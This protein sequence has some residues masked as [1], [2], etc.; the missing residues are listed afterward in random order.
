MRISD[1]DIL[2]VPGLGN[3][4]QNHWQLDG[5]APIRDRL[6][7]LTMPTLV[8]HGTAYPLFPYPHGKALAREIP[9]ARLVP[10]HGARVGDR[11]SR[12]LTTRDA[13]RRAIDWGTATVIVEPP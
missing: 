6:G 10:L 5:G 11:R 1:T 9:G 3:S 12:P 13:V 7:T 2:I 8:L 4:G